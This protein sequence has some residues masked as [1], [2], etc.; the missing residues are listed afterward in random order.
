MVVERPDPAAIWDYRRAAVE[1]IHTAVRRML[2]RHP[3]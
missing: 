1:R 2:C 3:E